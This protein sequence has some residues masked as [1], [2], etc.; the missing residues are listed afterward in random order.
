[1][2]IKILYQEPLNL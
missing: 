1:M 2:L